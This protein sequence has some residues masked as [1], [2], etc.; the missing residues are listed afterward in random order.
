MAP[1]GPIIPMIKGNGHGTNMVTL[2]RFFEQEG[3][4]FL[5]VSHLS[6]AIEL[7]EAG[8]KM[9]IFLLSI[10]ASK[11]RIYLFHLLHFLFKNWREK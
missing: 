4:P 2:G 9:P 10:I 5:G 3:C 11:A 8:I 7:R 6:E 1:L